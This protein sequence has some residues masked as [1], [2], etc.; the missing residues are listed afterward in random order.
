LNRF[1]PLPHSSLLLLANANVN[2]RAPG[3]EKRNATALHLAARAGPQPLVE[4]L[5][6]AGAD[7]SLGGDHGALPLE[8]ISSWF[9]REAGAV[10][11]TLRSALSRRVLAEG[12]VTKLGTERKVYIYKF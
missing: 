11:G 6:R 10:R 3:K 5:L 9:T 7:A 1:F 8:M 4:A 12:W 2:L